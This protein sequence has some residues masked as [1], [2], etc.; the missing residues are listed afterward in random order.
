MS[1]QE[2]HT[3]GFQ[4]ATDEARAS[5]REGG[6][7]IGAAL[8]GEDGKVLGQGHNVRVQKGSATGHVS[9]AFVLCWCRAVSHLVGCMCWGAY[10]LRPGCATKMEEW[11]VEVCRRDVC[12]KACLE[13]VGGRRG[14]CLACLIHFFPYKKK[15]CSSHE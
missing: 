8:V 1:Q 10:G 3:P 7:P 4:A 2:E 11:V 13:E 15:Q 6:I 12:G 5:A 14:A 9:L